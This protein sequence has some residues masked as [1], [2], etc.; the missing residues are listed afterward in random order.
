MGPIQSLEDL[1]GLVWR[2]SWMIVLITLIGTGLS[3]WY[4][5]SLPDTFETA[6]V[7][8]VESPI[9]SANG[10]NAQANA[11]QLLQTIEQRLTT[12]DNLIALIERHDLFSDAP[13]MTLEDRVAAIRS[14]IR[15]Q[16]VSSAA[17]GG[18]SA[19]IIAAQ[20]STADN[21]ARVA[22]DLAQSVLDLGAEGKR[23]TIDANT[24]FFKEEETRIWQTMTDLE[25]KIATYRE[26]NRGALPGA[27][28]ARQDELNQIE[29]SLRTLD[30]EIA[31]L[32]AEAA[33]IRALTSLRSTDRRR[34]EDIAQRLSV[35]TAQRAP[36]DAR[37]AALYSGL[38]DTA[39]IDRVL[40]GYER[41]L[42]QLQD[43][44]SVV[45]ARLAEAETS[46]RLSERQQTERFSMLERAIIPEYPLGA[47]GKRIAV[48]GAVVSAGA[49]LTL[50]FILDLMFPAIRSSSQMERELN[51]RPIVAIPEVP[52]RRRKAKGRGPISSLIGNEYA[53]LPSSGLHRYATIALGGAIVM[54]VA[55]AAMA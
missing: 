44:Y 30:Q 55:L 10:G 29:A 41:Q 53:S 37:K 4:A 38:G 33:S 3:A 34:L 16:G 11:L 17:G 2:R 48:A 39:E 28:E 6:A 5:K 49:A 35:L 50:A 23:A 9:I 52:A 7:L 26:A 1:F 15:F 18:L 45:S 20:A 32:Q 8:Q 24:A 54:V 43:Q 31:G 27:R 36:L 14:S 46:Q 21:A 51:I 47:G 25:S 19:I 22:N 13:S 40:S 42:R 12:R